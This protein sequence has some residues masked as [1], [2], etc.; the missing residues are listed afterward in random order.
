MKDFIKQLEQRFQAPLP[1][2]KAQSQ[3]ASF[4]RLTKEYQYKI[5]KNP[6]REAGVLC[7]LYPKNN[8]WH[9]PLMQRTTRKHD[10]HS[11]QISFPG[12]YHEESDP[13]YEFTA[14]RETEEEFGIPAKDIQIIGKLTPL[15]IPV[16]EFLVH[17]FVGFLKNEPQFV[18]DASEVEAIL[19]PTLEHLL[20]DN[21][22]KLTPMT[23]SSGF[24]MDNVP[25][26]DVNGEIVWGATS[27]MLN[28]FL[29]IV[30]ETQNKTV[31]L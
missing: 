26:F 12:G 20:K 29:T 17:P 30:K 28:E 22:K 18:P 16:S 21:T 5:P 23:F 25:Y 31:L 13:D 15:Y 11:R 24:T 27:M 3:M 8:T 10:P 2:M 7:L 14:L 1:G 4:S 19:E 9:I 6:R